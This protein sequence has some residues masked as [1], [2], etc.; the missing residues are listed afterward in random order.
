MRLSDICNLLGRDW[1]PLAKSLEIPESDIN[2]IE[3]EYPGNT[4]QQAM[5]MLRLW[6]TQ[7]ENR[8]TGNSLEKALRKIGRDDIVN[9]C[10][11]NVELVTDDLEKAVAKVQLDQTGFDSVREEIGSSR[12]ATLRR[13][14]SLDVSFDE[15][16]LMKVRSR[17]LDGALAAV[18]AISAAATAAATFWPCRSCCVRCSLRPRQLAAS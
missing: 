10:I 1:I 3:T 2:L 17:S 16:D 7:S 14:T 4:T 18:I 8:V 13:N 12:N 5:V 11:F 9:Q 6:M 15:Q